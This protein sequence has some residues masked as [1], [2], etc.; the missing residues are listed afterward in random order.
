MGE[1]GYQFRGRLEIDIYVPFCR[2][3][4]CWGH[5]DNKCKSAKKCDCGGDEHEG[6]C[7][8]MTCVSC[9]GNHKSWNR[10]KCPVYLDMV[11]AGILQV[12]K[13]HRSYLL[14]LRK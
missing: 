2:K 14:A 13:L 10:N 3:C 11:K 12:N 5:Y 9:K 7:G 4:L 8:K 1:G 6:K